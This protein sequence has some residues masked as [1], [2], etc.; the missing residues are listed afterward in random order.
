LHHSDRGS[1]YASYEYRQRLEQAQAV[2]SMSRKKTHMR[3][4][5]TYVAIADAPAQAFAR[6]ECRRRDSSCGAA[7]AGRHLVTL[8]FDSGLKYLSTDVNRRK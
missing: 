5:T 8:M 3:Q 1:Q 4:D 6:R 7:R 2:T